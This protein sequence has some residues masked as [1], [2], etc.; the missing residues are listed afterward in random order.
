MSNYRVYNWTRKMAHLDPEYIS[1][2]LDGSTKLRQ[3]LP[4]FFKSIASKGVFHVEDIYLGHPILVSKQSGKREFTVYAL[5]FKP[6]CFSLGE[7]RAVLLAQNM[8]TLDRAVQYVD[9]LMETALPFWEA[10][11][12]WPVIPIPVYVTADEEKL[13]RG[14][15]EGYRKIMRKVFLVGMR[16][17]LGYA[18][19]VVPV[20]PEDK[21]NRPPKQRK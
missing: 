10:V 11:R 8:S 17:V 20:D 7:D 9:G 21:P 1:V 5:D 4:G 2:C 13:L 3:R 12:R 19:D 16:D 14:H 18:P 15:P 6:E